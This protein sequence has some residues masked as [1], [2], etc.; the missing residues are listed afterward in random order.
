MSIDQFFLV[1]GFALSAGAFALV[2]KGIGR[3]WLILIGLTCAVAFVG[4]ASIMVVKQ[5][6][7]AEHVEVV[8]RKI[9]TIIGR[10]QKT[11]D[12]ILESL[13]PEDFS[14]VSESLAALMQTDSIGNE[15]VE[16]VDRANVSHKVRVYFVKQ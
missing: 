11:A 6:Q 13:F 1:A 3:L 14:A 4:A 8:S 2:L 12:E 9:V 15:V 7:H 16:T 5:H 10:G